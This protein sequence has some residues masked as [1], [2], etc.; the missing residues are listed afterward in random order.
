MDSL[1]KFLATL[2]KAK[3]VPI[4]TTNV[5]IVKLNMNPTNNGKDKSG[6]ITNSKKDKKGGKKVFMPLK[7]LKK[8]KSSGIINDLEEPVVPLS[9]EEGMKNEEVKKH[10]YQFLLKTYSNE[11]LDFYDE[12]LAFQNIAFEDDTQI[13]KSIEQICC[14][15]LGMGEIE[16]Q[17]DVVISFNFDVLEDFQDKLSKN[18][19]K[20]IFKLLFA[21]A[22][23]ILK[24]SISYFC[25]RR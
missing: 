21:E 11:Y 25:I 13:K 8:S 12:I 7:K 22:K 14:K 17:K 5:K 4:E 1:P 6:K 24:K 19:F 3:K 18:E 16:E 9:F 23:V 15:Y 20:N 10:F 2:D